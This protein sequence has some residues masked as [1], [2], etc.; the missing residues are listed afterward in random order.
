M[1]TSLCLLIIVTLFF[2]NIQPAS[3]TFLEGLEDIPLA[4]GLKQIENGVLSFGNEEIRLVEV[5][6]SA[7]NTNFNKIKFFYNKTLPQMGWK[8]KKQNDFRLTWEREGETLEIN[9][10]ST[11]PQIIRLT[12]KS[13]K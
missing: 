3:S 5:F 9:R 2:A 6:C 12:V 1:K 10:E 8:I 7:E 11:D 13:K 4:D